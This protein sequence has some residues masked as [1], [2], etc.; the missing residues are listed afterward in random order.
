MDVWGVISMPNEAVQKP[1]LS[2]AVVVVFD[3]E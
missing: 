1:E 2:G 3:S